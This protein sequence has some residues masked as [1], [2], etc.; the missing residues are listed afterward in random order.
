MH[1]IPDTPCCSPLGRKF[2]PNCG[3]PFSLQP[4][5]VSM[6][7]AALFQSDIMLFEQ[8]EDPDQFTVVANC[9]GSSLPLVSTLS[10]GIRFPYTRSK[11]GV[12]LWKK[13]QK[14][15]QISV[16]MSSNNPVKQKI[17]NE[18]ECLIGAKISKQQKSRYQLSIDHFNSV[19]ASLDNSNE[20]S[21]DNLLTF[22]SHLLLSDYTTYCIKDLVYGLMYHINAEGM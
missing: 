3:F 8:N 19:M 7:Q 6:A 13:S 11:V 21:E 5:Q 20:I 9:L 1:A 17:Y 10:I 14:L 16:H 12:V 15:R 2:Q 18:K 22:I 4:Q